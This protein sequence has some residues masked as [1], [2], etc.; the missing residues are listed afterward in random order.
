MRQGA[1]DLD[2]QVVR[3]IMYKVIFEENN[4]I[5]KDEQNYSAAVK[6][7]IGVVKNFVD[8]EDRA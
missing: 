1:K 8:K 7:L 4:F 6:K 3:N 5:K 2:P